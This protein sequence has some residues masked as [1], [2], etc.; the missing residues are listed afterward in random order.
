MPT[1]DWRVEFFRRAFLRHAPRRYTVM[2]TPKEAKRLD[3][4]YTERRGV[5]T[6]TMIK[7]HLGGAITLAAPAAVDG[8]AHLLPLDID[9]G[10]IAAICALIA[11]TVGTVNTTPGERIGQE[12]PVT[13]L[14]TSR[15]Q[16]D[17]AVDE[18]D[19]TRVS[20]GQPVE[21]LIDALGAP[22]LNGTVRR[23]A[24]QSEEGQSVTAYKVT[25]E[26]EPGD[27]PIKPGMTA[28]A[29]ISSDQRKGV[30]QVPAAAVRTENGASV[31]SV[32]TTDEDGK[33][34]IRTQLVEVGLRAGEQVEIRSGLSEEQQVLVP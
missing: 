1:S 21:V 5:I 30:L 20:I 11:G 16:V 25:V 34:T 27:R 17:I 23:I 24:P 14:D 13:L 12:A 7:G 26:V 4:K 15:Y 33:Q 8:Y 22:A 31:V 32:V 9:A 2:L 19:V 18:I 28:S 3:Q 6:D 10:G 29:S